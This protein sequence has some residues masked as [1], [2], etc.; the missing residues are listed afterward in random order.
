MNDGSGKKILVSD[1]P[2]KGPLGRPRHR[3][4]NY[5]KMAET[6]WSMRVLPGFIWLKKGEH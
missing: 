4:N 6:K 5:M 1:S 2:G 3:Q